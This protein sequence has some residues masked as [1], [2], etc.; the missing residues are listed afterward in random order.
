MEDAMKKT[1]VSLL[2]IGLVF[3]LGSCNEPADDDGGG[4]NPTDV[5]WT[6]GEGDTGATLDLT[7]DSN[8]YP[9][10]SITLADCPNISN[11]TGGPDYV[12]G[13]IS[14]Y[15]EAILHAI[16]YNENDEEVTTG[17]SLA[18]FSILKENTWSDRN[19]LAE[20]YNLT[21]RANKSATPG[22]D[23]KYATSGMPLYLLVQ[24]SYDQPAPSGAV[25]KVVVQKLTLKLRTDLPT[26]TVQYGSGITTEGNKITFDD[27]MYSDAAA[28]FTFPDTFPALSDLTGKKLVFDFTIEATAGTDL[29]KEFQ[30]HVQA[31]GADG[32]FNGQNP[33][34]HSGVGQFYVTLDDHNPTGDYNQ[35]YD[36]TTKAGSFKIPFNDLIAASNA[37]GDVNDLKGP[38]DL[39]A[40]RICNNGTTWQSHE[41][42][43]SYSIIFNSIKAE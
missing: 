24:G 26:F 28:L 5:I 17:N 32:A 23:P 25:T 35:T 3:F 12:L 39:T 7:E 42:N 40:V 10:R 37:S 21:S 1:I 18:Q 15:G 6:W 16:L 30:I 9:G 20:S 36:G 29:N 31:A 41:R 19:K 27:V 13:D 4:G 22:S 11:G 14:Y 43:R 2:I 34:D 38:F 33:P 8:N